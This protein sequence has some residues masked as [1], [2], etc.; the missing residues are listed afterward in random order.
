L[1]CGSL[2]VIAA[3]PAAGRKGWL[4]G[5]TGGASGGTQATGH[6]ASAALK[7]NHPPAI[8]WERMRQM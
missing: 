6:P 8:G 2:Q 7:S 4:G 3:A 1:P 5:A